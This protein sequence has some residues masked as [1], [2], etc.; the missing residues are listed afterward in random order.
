MLLSYWT[1]MSLQLQKQRF[2]GYIYSNCSCRYGCILG[3]ELKEKK[4]EGIEILPYVISC[5][6]NK[7][8]SKIANYYYSIAFRHWSAKGHMSACKLKRLMVKPE[9]FLFF[10]KCAYLMISF[11]P[12]SPLKCPSVFFIWCSEPMTTTLLPTNFTCQNNF[13]PWTVSG[14][15]GETQGNPNNFIRWI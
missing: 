14:T 12:V 8:P 2:E 4:K 15:E 1:A 5:L 10:L 6:E 9:N 11:P 13:V 3:K 7:H